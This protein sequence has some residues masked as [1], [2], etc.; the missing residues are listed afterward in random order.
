MNLRREA[1]VSISD[2][3]I[4]IFEDHIKQLN[5]TR[6]RIAGELTTLS[7]RAK[8]LASHDLGISLL[9]KSEGWSEMCEISEIALLGGDGNMDFDRELHLDMIEV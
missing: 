3:S 7:N 1:S 8:N 5:L 9:Y 6:V 4:K 2:S